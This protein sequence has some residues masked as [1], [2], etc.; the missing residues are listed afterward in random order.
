MRV[1]LDYLSE[2][3]LKHFLGKITFSC[4]RERKVEEAVE[5]LD[6]CTIVNI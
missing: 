3:K 6:I 5:D 4:K 1:N 2:K